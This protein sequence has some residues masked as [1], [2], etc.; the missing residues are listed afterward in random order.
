MTIRAVL[1]F[2]NLLAGGF[3]LWKYFFKNSLFLSLAVFL[4][5]YGALIFYALA[6]GMPLNFFIVNFPLALYPFALLGIK[7]RP[8]M[9]FWPRQPRRLYHLLA[10]AIFVILILGILHMMKAPLFERDGLG[11]WLTKA[12]MIVLDRSFLSEDFFNPWRIQDS[13]RYPLFLPLLEGSF[14]FQ[15]A[16]NEL[17]VKLVF[18]YIWF[19]NL[20]MIYENLVLRSGRAAFFSVI[21]LAVVPAYYLMADGSLHTGYADI[22]ISLFYLSAGIFLLDYFPTGSKITLAGAGL[23]VA[24]SAFTKNEGW[25]FGLSVLLVL[26]IARRKFSDLVLFLAFA[27]IPN[28]PWLLTMIRLPNLYQEHYLRRIPEILPRLVHIPLILKNAVFEIFN[29]RHWGI[30]WPL[31]LAF[32]IF[33]KSSSV[34]R[35]LLSVILITIACYLGTYLLTSWDISFQMSVSFA[36]LLLHV[37]PLTVLLA[38]LHIIGIKNPPSSRP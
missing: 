12:K 34:I 28:L 22:P 17:T 38:A 32:F 2:I 20:G 14:M 24:F 8:G 5:A 35:Y 37:T 27:L 36:R 6:A 21:A 13:P 16:V 1:F 4:G 26:I 18:V 33:F 19:L 23:A 15:T 7:S 30:L 10:A 29:I 3:F 11:I 25:A 31:I 9:T